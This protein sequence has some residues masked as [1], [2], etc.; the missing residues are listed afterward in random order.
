M[1]LYKIRFH[2]SI[3]IRKFALGSYDLMGKRLPA[4]WK[5]STSSSGT[6]YADG[7]RLDSNF[8]WCYW[9]LGQ[10]TICAARRWTVTAGEEKRQSRFYFR[11][12]AGLV[13]AAART[14]L[15]WRRSAGHANFFPDR[16][17]RQIFCLPLASVDR[18]RQGKGPDTEAYLLPAAD[19]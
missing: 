7:R 2:S 17:L 14:P 4:E 12:R 6:T 16:T 9:I 13:P 5:Q 15:A 8:S 1:S 3:R 10:D 11:K 19:R 18:Q